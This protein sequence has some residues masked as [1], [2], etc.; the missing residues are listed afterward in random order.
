MALFSIVITATEVAKV[1]ESLAKFDAN[2][3]GVASVRAVNAVTDRAYDTATS[4]MIAGINLTQQY[5][6]QRMH[7]RHASDPRKPEAEIVASSKASRGTTLGTYGAKVITKA[8]NWSNGSFTPG[9]FGPNPR[10]PGSLLPW[11]PRIGDAQR[12]IAPDLKAAGFTA[13]VIRG[14][15]DQFPNAFVIPVGGRLLTVSRAKGTRKIKTLYGPSVLQLF[16]TTVPRI[17]TEVA[18]DL[19]KAVQAEVDKELGNLI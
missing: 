5:V 18:T 6:D 16:R 4:R 9:A 13:S 15:I 11:K 1:A 19:H 8:V 3:L 10:K 12:G 7:V 2:T 17:H 14:R